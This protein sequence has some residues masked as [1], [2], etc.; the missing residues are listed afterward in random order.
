MLS[1][2]IH[3]LTED[4]LT[5]PEIA[6]FNARIIRLNL[7]TI[8]ANVTV[9]VLSSGFL[10]SCISTKFLKQEILFTIN[11]KTTKYCEIFQNYSLFEM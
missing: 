10:G 6:Y 2:N 7:K 4:C 5:V 11:T 3:L 8:A 1:V 9:F